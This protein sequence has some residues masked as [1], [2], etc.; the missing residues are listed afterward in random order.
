MQV[1]TITLNPAYDLIGLIQD[2]INIGEVNSVNTLSLHPA[3]KGVN[4]A[5]VLTR[6]GYSVTVTGYLGDGNESGFMKMLKNNEIIDSFVRIEGNTRTNITITDKSGSTNLN[7]NGFCVTS[8]K[9]INGLND[10][11]DMLLSDTA[12]DFITVNGSLPVGFGTI[13]FVRLLK[14]IRGQAKNILLDTSGRALAAGIEAKPDFIKPNQKELDELC[15]LTGKKVEDLGIQNII[16]S[17]G[18]K[19][20]E[21]ITPDE[22]ISCRSQPVAD[23]V[24]TTGAGDAMVAGIVDGVLKG[25]TK[26]KILQQGCA[27]GSFAVSKHG[28]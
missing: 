16:V 22:R 13:D 23:I 28:V 1:L 25:W 14:R 18:E 10:R 11:I 12:Y 21:W 3:G 9:D 6:L 27:F 19:G 5:N 7:F 4:V 24:S 26:D 8:Q 2:K 17:K 15:C 20:A